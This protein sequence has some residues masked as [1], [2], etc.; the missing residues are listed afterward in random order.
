MMALWKSCAECSAPS[1]TTYC[2]DCRPVQTAQRPSRAAGYDAAWDKLSKRARRLQ[3]WCTD[4]LTTDDLTCD[5]LP[6]AWKRKNRGLVI[7]LQDV[8]VVCRSCNGKRGAARGPR[9]EGATGPAQE[10]RRQEKFASHTPGGM[11]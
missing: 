2:D 7:R 9:G 10:P 5:H 11:P 3:P 1:E 8:E 4:C 6:I